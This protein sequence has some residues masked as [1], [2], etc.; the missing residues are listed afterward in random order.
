MHH[1]TRVEDVFYQPLLGVLLTALSEPGSETF[2]LF[3]YHEYWQPTPTSPPWRLLSEI[4]NSNRFMQEYTSV[5][6]AARVDKYTG[7]VVVIGIM[8]WSNSTRLTWFSNIS[9]WPVYIYIANQPKGDRGRTTAFACHHI[10]YM[11]KLKKGFEEF[12]FECYGIK[13]SD[14][15]LCF[16]RREAIQAIYVLLLDDEFV[17][18]YVYGHDMEF[19]DCVKH[20]F[21]PWFMTHSMDYPEK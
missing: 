8:I 11:P 14:D 18:V 20:R 13:P 9:L 15:I 6:R 16:V 17:H 4:F 12:Y 7:E 5:F 21:F 1:I 19:C 2:H 10:A 3:S